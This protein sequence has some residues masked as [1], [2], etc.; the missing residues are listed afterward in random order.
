MSTKQLSTKTASVLELERLEK[1]INTEAFEAFYHIGQKLFKIKDERLYENAGFKKWREYCE[2]GRVKVDTDSINRSE[3]D[4]Y[5]RASLLRPKLGLTEPQLSKRVLLELCKCQTDNDAKRVAKKAISHAKKHGVPVT[6]TLIIQIR[7]GD[8]ETG[9]TKAAMAELTL[10][11]HL[12]RMTDKVLD[13]RIALE[14]MPVSEW[15]DVPSVVLT[16]FKNEANALLKFL[17]S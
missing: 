12:E 8:N 9:K 16:R 3:A 13:M 1:E 15:D 17:R 4:R 7:D 14:A 10:T 5:I 6:S 2:S 11:K